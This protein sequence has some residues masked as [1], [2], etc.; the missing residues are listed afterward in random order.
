ML[1]PTRIF[2]TDSIPIHFNDSSASILTFKLDTKIH[3][4]LN[5]MNHY[6][7]KLFTQRNTFVGDVEMKYFQFNTFQF[8]GL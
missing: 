8:Y 2:Q 6:H 5:A 1:R 4:V 3:F 7:E